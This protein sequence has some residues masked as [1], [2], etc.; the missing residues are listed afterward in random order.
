[1]PQ[2]GASVCLRRHTG[3]RRRGEFRRPPERRRPWPTCTDNIQVPVYAYA[4][5]ALREASER[6]S[7]NIASFRTKNPRSTPDHGA[8]GARSFERRSISARRCLKRHPDRE[9][10]SPTAAA[11]S[12]QGLRVKTWT[13]ASG[14]VKR[15]VCQSAQA[16]GQGVPTGGRALQMRGSREALAAHNGNRTRDG[17]ND[18]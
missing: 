2:S 9:S 10:S 8:D 15:R 17:T 7:Q 11:G 14:R 3:T 16:S 6:G 4:S 1:L 13:V 12:C 18:G 5:K